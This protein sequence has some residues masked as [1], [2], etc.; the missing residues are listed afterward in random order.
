MYPKN[1]SYY[2]LLKAFKNHDDCIYEGIYC[3]LSSFDIVITED[4]IYF[5]KEF[6]Q[7]ANNGIDQNI[8]DLSKKIEKVNDVLELDITDDS[9]GIVLPKMD[10]DKDYE[11]ESILKNGKQATKIK[12]NNSVIAMFNKSAKMLGIE[13]YDKI[14]E[15]A[16]ILRKED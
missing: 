15:V 9:I 5:D 4:Q 8:F 2:N 12:Q 1:E 3:N 16:D 11:V 6:K 13:D 14:D 10:L 7:V